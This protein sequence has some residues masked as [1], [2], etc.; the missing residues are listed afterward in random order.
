VNDLYIDKVVK[1]G[2]WRFVFLVKL[3]DD[4]RC[5][6]ELSGHDV[7]NSQGSYSRKACTVGLEA[8]DD[9]N[10][11]HHVHEAPLSHATR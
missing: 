7:G 5:V 6:G 3:L 4:L 9:G 8:H 1:C 10:R 2:E 11:R